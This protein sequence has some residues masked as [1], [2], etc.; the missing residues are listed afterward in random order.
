MRHCALSN[1]ENNEN[2]KAG[3]LPAFS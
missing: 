3:M 1:A 2:K